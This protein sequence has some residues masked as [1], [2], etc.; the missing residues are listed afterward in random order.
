[1]D[2]QLLKVTLAMEP[3]LSLPSYAYE[4]DVY[5][6]QNSVNIMERNN[7]LVDSDR[8]AISDIDR[9][10]YIIV[11]RN[12]DRH[13]HIIIDRNSWGEP[14]RFQNTVDRN[15]LSDM[16]RNTL[17][18]ME[19]NSLSVSVRT[20]QIR[21]LSPIPPTGQP[22][23][24][25]P[26]LE[27]PTT[28]SS[29]DLE[30]MVCSDNMNYSVVTNS[31]KTSEREVVGH[32]KQRRRLPFI[33][34]TTLTKNR[35]SRSFDSGISNLLSDSGSPSPPL[36]GEKEHEGEGSIS[37]RSGNSTSYLSSQS[38]TS[39]PVPARSPVT[40]SKRASFHAYNRSSPA[41]LP[42]PPV[43][44]NS[45]S[46][47]H[48]KPGFFSARRFS[49]QNSIGME[50]ASNFS[51][52]RTLSPISVSPSS[53]INKSP[54]PSYSS[55]SKSSP[56]LRGSPILRPSYSLHS[57]ESSG[58]PPKSPDTCSPLSP[59]SSPPVS[60]VSRR[61]LPETPLK[62]S[63]SKELPTSRMGGTTSRAVLGSVRDP[64]PNCDYPEKRIA[65]QPVTSHDSLD[66]GVYSRSNTSD[67]VR[68]TLSCYSR[69]N[70]SS[71]ILNT[72]SPTLTR[73][74]SWRKS[75]GAKL[76]EPPSSTTLEFDS[77][78]Q[79]RRQSLPGGQQNERLSNDVEGLNLTPKRTYDNLSKSN[80]FS[81]HEARCPAEPRYPPYDGDA[82]LKYII[83]DRP[84]LHPCSNNRDH[85]DCIES[86]LEVDSGGL[87]VPKLR[88]LKSHSFPPPWS[89]EAQEGGGLNQPSGQHPCPTHDSADEKRKRW[90]FC[91]NYMSGSRSERAPDDDDDDDD[92]ILGSDDD[93][94][95]A[96]SDYVKGGYHP[97]KIGDLFHNRYHVVRKL[98]WGHFSTV[99]LCW[100]LN[101]KKF[102]ALKVVKSAAHYTETALDEIKLLKCVRETDG[103]NPFRNRTVQLLDD[104]KISGINGTHVCMVFEVLGHNLLKFIIRSNYQ[105]IPLTNVKIMMKQVLEGLDYL[106]SSCNII[107]TDIKPENIL[108]CVDESHIRRIAA[109]AT[110]CHKLGL[111]LPGSAVSTAPPEQQQSEMSVKISKTKKKKLKKRA[112]RSVVIMENDLKHMED[113]QHVEFPGEKLSNGDKFQPDLEGDEKDRESSLQEASRVVFKKDENDEVEEG[114]KKNIETH[115]SHEDHMK[116]LAELE[117]SAVVSGKS[118]MNKNAISMDDVEKRKSFADMKLVDFTSGSG[119]IEGIPGLEEDCAGQLETEDSEDSKSKGSSMSVTSP[120]EGGDSLVTNNN[121]A[122]VV[123]GGVTDEDARDMRKLPMDPVNE[124]CLDL[125]VK[126]ADLGNACWVHHHFTEDI[127]TRQYRSLEVLLG[128][129]YGPAADIWSTACMAFEMATGDYLFEPHSGEDYTRDEDHLAHIIELVGTIPRNIAFS[130]KYSKEFFKKNGELRHINKLKPWPLYDVL[131]EKYEW[132]PQTAKEFADFLIPMLAFDP[133]ERATAKE[134]LAHPFV[135]NL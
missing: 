26:E 38:P 98:G 71:P 47:K 46:Y 113:V 86:A 33:S 79:N 68:E 30:N 131:T 8:N 67:S 52:S 64:N 3:S 34:S 110:H 95:E 77:I 35:S 101:E 125:Q 132:E 48:S 72:N 23:P 12:N 108:V 74:H 28:P 84:G 10:N 27:E 121:N 59:T 43:P 107:H 90:I 56:Q 61:M 22:F 2:L 120:E 80:G 44:P 21:R 58:S 89:C 105:G 134:S 63:V 15:A 76:P 4:S 37:H 99:W 55:S 53:N 49:E 127:Q 78:F 14:E 1:V 109:E 17:A 36:P 69:A 11:D 111:K 124:I 85:T 100:D 129:G 122:V 92:E 62:Q 50:T 83:H 88:E 114:A 66:S 116:Q 115:E 91:K 6:D 32:R 133:K 57:N 117:L 75:Y 94:Q 102:V 42:K 25:V 20:D 5:A 19:R 103:T 18:V 41:Q 16:D 106:H 9:N 39:S 45:P 93:E 118:N 104:F 31:P 70:T 128:S 126:I 7:I 51:N 40:P 112:K 65:W 119:S 60:R 29:E 13:S 73:H 96:P 24:T 81:S 87:E 130:G 97:V 54:S 123:P 82:T 135:A